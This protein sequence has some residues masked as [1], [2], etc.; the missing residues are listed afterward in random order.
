MGPTQAAPPLPSDISVAFIKRMTSLSGPISR[1]SQ[2]VDLLLLSGK[3]SSILP[4]LCSLE[5]LMANTD[6]P[7]SS[8]LQPLSRAD[9]LRVE[10]STDITFFGNAAR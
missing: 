2:A 10:N 6:S 9:Q 5:L 3:G 1:L 7:R 4:A 8:S